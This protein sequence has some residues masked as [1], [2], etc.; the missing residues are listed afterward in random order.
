MTYKEEFIELNYSALE[1]TPPD[2]SATL[3]SYLHNQPGCSDKKPAVIICPGGGYENHAYHE[4]EPVALKFAA[5][6][7]QSFVLKYS[8]AP[9]KFP[10]ALLELSKSVAHIREKSD[11]YLVDCNRIFLLGFS[12]GGHLAASL[13]VLWK[14]PF[15]QRVLGY[16]NNENQPNGMVL[17]YPVIVND[18]EI[19]HRGS[20]E[21]LIGKNPDKELA[22]LVSLEKNVSNLTP[23][24]FLW[25]TFEDNGVDVRNS[26]IFAEMLREHKI[27]TELH[28]YPT[29]HHGLGLAANEQGEQGVCAEWFHHAVRFLKNI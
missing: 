17:C 10:A 3:F 13:G 12:A 5:E 18:F 28:V 27:R 7:F 8:V 23:P 22:E 21:A 16:N 19:G 4:G 2:C 1:L 25:H 11:E 14:E 24:T 20:F 9:T 6:G 26:L 15:I 29:G